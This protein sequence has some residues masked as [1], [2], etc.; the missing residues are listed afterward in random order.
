MLAEHHESSS[1]EC[2]PS[3]ISVCALPPRA[4]EGTKARSS[5]ANGWHSKAQTPRDRAIPANRG[6]NLRLGLMAGIR[7]DGFLA[8][9]NYIFFKARNCSGTS[10]RT[11]AVA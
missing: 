9:T 6:D 4:L 10:L 3:C 2:T 7:N 8:R 1:L 11:G 5:Q